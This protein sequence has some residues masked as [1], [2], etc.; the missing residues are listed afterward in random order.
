MR[1]AEIHQVIKALTRLSNGEDITRTSINSPDFD[2]SRWRFMDTNNP[3]IAGHSL[4]GSTAIAAGAD[5]RFQPSSILVFDP[6]IQRKLSF[7]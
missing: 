6:A 4:G 7:S 3:V 5:D 1:K 2:W